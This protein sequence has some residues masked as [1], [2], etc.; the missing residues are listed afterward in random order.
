[1]RERGGQKSLNSGPASRALPRS[2]LKRHVKGQR[3]AK[4][5]EREIRKELINRWGERPITEITRSDVISLIEEIADRPAP[6][7]AHLILG[8]LRSLFNWAIARDTY[9]LV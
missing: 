8:H 4:D 3:R 2:F 7:Y 5:T 6:Y 9:G 1:M